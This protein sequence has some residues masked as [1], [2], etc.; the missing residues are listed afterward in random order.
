MTHVGLLYLTMFH[1]KTYFQDVQHELNM[2]GLT[3]TDL[4]R[5]MGVPKPQISRWMNLH[6]S[7]TLESVERIDAALERLIRERIEEEME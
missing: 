5:A 7:P 4:A 1:S 6:V 2:H 3:R